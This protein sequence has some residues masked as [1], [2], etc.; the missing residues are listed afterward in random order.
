MKYKKKAIE[1]RE[2][3]FLTMPMNSAKR[4]QSR[5]K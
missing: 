3:G 4:R 1:K 5:K 2:D